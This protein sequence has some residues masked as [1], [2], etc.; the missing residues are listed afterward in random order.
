MPTTT[1]DCAAAMLEAIPAAMRVIRR[2][3]RSH[4]LPGMS[5]PQFRALAFLNRHG[6]ATLSAAAEHVGTTLPSTSR[7]V[8]SLVEQQLVR[9][10]A[11]SP[12]R[13]TV[14]LEITARGRRVLETAG[15]A[16]VEQLASRV[17]SLS[18]GEVDQLKK[19]MG[20]LRRVFAAG[21]DQCQPQ[22]RGSRC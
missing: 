21:D 11:G 12:D 8:Q 7:M 4:R 18:G 22:G 13:R 17:G 10:S 14:C 20:L 3:M 1:R 6:R 9:R 15:R 19:A 5:V 16:T 2:H